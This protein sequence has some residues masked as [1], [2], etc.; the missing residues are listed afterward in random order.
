[1]SDTAPE[2]P[3]DGQEKFEE[4]NDEVRR[5]THRLQFLTQGTD[6]ELRRKFRP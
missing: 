2:K 4:G 6:L 3:A 1:M 5:A